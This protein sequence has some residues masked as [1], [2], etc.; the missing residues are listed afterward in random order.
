MHP[1]DEDIDLTIR[2]PRVPS[3]NAVK[4]HIISNT[5]TSC[6]SKFD[7]PD[8]VVWVAMKGSP[9]WSLILHKA[10]GKK[11]SVDDMIDAY[12][13]FN[14]INDPQ[15]RNYK[16]VLP[17]LLT[18]R[19]KFFQKRLWTLSTALEAM[20]RE[21]SKSTPEIP[22]SI[23]EEFGSG[24]SSLVHEN[25][26][27]LSPTKVLICLV[28]EIQEHARAI[29]RMDGYSSSVRV[30]K[31]VPKFSRMF[32]S[33]HL[34]LRSRTISKAPPRSRAAGLK[35][36]MERLLPLSG[37]VDYLIKFSRDTFPDEGVRWTVARSSTTV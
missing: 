17:F 22:P 28:F 31:L 32:E 35:S 27:G 5:V 34:L 37:G 13:F 18:R 6:L 7:S 19:T 30:E 12:K 36:A 16:D 1:I 14:I 4:R 26:P 33:C 29:D 15:T 9:E 3:P 23:D 11:L 21:W 8:E 25:Y 24:F 20:E 2:P 10:N